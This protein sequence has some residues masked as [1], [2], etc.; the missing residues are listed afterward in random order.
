[1]FKQ[2]NS[3]RVKFG[4]PAERFFLTTVLMNA[5]GGK[6]RNNFVLY[7]IGSIVPIYPNS[8]DIKVKFVLINIDSGTGRLN[9]KMNARLRNLGS[10]LYPGGTNTTPVTQETNQIYCIFKSQFARA[11]N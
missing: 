4:F 2:F 5:K 1:M 11:L 3:V 10:I 9:I 7:L 6:Y 8:E